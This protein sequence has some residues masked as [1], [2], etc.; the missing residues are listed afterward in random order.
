[1]EK[2]LAGTKGKYCFGDTLT[3]ADLFFH[4]QV[5][6]AVER[7][8]IDINQFPVIKGIYDNLNSVQEVI[9]ALPKN[10]PDAN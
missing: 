3:A 7:F 4:P 9:D 8:G 1:M 10:Q 2:F 5:A 6:A